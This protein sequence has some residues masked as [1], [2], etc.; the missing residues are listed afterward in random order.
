MLTAYGWRIR[1]E[2]HMLA[3]VLG[4]EYRRYQRRTTRLVPFVY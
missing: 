3:D 1:A 2:E 4:E